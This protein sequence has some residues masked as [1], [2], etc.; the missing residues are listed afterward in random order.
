MADRTPDTAPRRTG[1]PPPALRLPPLL[2]AVSLGG[3]VGAA[4]RHG[5]GI[6]WP[7]SES[8]PLTTLAVNIVGC[9]A[10]GAL[11]AL[12]ETGAVTA[13]WVRPA[14]G[15][16]VISSFTTFAT[17]TLDADRVIAADR[18]AAAALYLVGTV[19][20]ALLALWAGLATT[21]RLA[22]R[23]PGG[24]HGDHRTAGGDQGA[25]T[26]ARPAA[27]DQEAPGKQL[28]QRSAEPPPGREHREHRTHPDP[29]DHGGRPGQG[30]AGPC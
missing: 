2:V 8:S 26:A 1:A 5:T 23:R 16:G 22:T 10:M 12:I 4:A 21:R 25:A 9:A 17:Y 11:M 14:L 19:G 27:G 29:R 13:P 30:G 6:L 24:G 15:T 7:G 20:A 28:P 3:M 18:Y